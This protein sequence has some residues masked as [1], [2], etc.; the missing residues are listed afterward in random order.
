MTKK[1]KIILVLL[2]L[3][4]LS[5]F[6]AACDTQTHTHTA[7]D[8][9]HTDAS[10]HWHECTEDGE[11]MDEAAHTAGTE[12]K[13]DGTNHW[14]ECTVCGA[15]MNETAHTPDAA[16]WHT[17]GTNHWHEC[18]VCNAVYDEQEHTNSGY[19][20]DSEKHWA[21]CSICGAEYGEG[22]HTPST[23]YES[24]GTNHWHPCVICGEP[25]ETEE[26]T[27]GSEL[28]SDGITQWYEC[29]ECGERSQETSHTHEYKLNEDGTGLICWCNTE[30]DIDRFAIADRLRIELGL[31]VENGAVAEDSTTSLSI[32]LTAADTDP[33]LNGFN[34]SSVVCGSSALDEEDFTVS[35]EALTFT[36]SAFGLLYG[37]QTLVFRFMNADEYVFEVEVPVL[38]VSQVITT[39]AQLSQFGTIAKA[40]E[41]DQWT[42]GG[43]FELG[44]N[45]TNAG[46]MTEFLSYASAT[47]NQ[48]HI[49]TGNYGFKGVFDGRGYAIDGLTKSSNVNDGAFIG[50]LHK[51]G[52]IRN[53]SFT[54]AVYNSMTGS[55]VVNGGGGLVENVYVQ[56]NQFS[57]GATWREPN[58][59]FYGHN[60]NTNANNAGAVV[61]NCVVEF[62]ENSV[63]LLGSN[64]LLDWV[65][66]AAPS[67]RITVENLY[68]ILPDQGGSDATARGKVFGTG[69]SGDTYNVYT[70]YDGLK[71]A[72]SDWSDWNSD[73][74]DTSAGYPV[75]K[76]RPEGDWMTDGTQH[77]H[78]KGEEQIDVG[79]HTDSGWQY[80]AESHW[81]V[82]DVCGYKV[83]AD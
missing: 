16:G 43:Y 14:Q 44:A 80:D 32:D 12:W 69:T 34:V 71:T 64:I 7:D 51:D 19:Q 48:G 70:S 46:T 22:A 18:G 83:A 38:L 52:V 39:A 28:L 54:N 62:A 23:E 24:D 3:C 15:K 45:I 4:L 75:F 17:D 66:L 41:A 58:S 47:S 37:E 33:A 59:T 77:W 55:F 72:V 10:S 9:W 63:S 50:Y 82:C 36:P 2:C 6:A 27:P 26:H 5:V 57:F 68:V 78:M 40:C 60:Y 79:T 56:Y 30:K 73:I 42:Y 21:E 81:K 31:S 1:A 49:I 67:D 25:M 74:W 8:V 65:A 11:K 76:E 61:R 20:S 13:S 29:T 35:G 53:V